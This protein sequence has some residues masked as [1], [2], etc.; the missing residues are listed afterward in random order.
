MR[1]FLFIAFAGILAGFFMT[2][3]N[4]SSSHPGFKKTSTG[5]YYKFYHK[6]GDTTQPKIAEFAMVEMVYGTPDSVLFDSRKLPAS[7][8]PMKIPMIRSIYKG[9]IYEG[10]EMMHVG[11][12]AVFQ[13]NADSV[14]KKL[15]RMRKLPAFVDT[16]KDVYFAIKLVG[17]KTPQQ[18]QAEESARL[19]KLQNTESKERVAYLK[20][21]NITVKPTKDGLY[22]IPEKPGK[23]R[24]PKI[25][26]RVSVHYTGYLLNGKKFDSSRDRGKPF[27]FTLGK[28]QVIPGW[29]EGIAMLRKGGT[30][31]LIVPSSLGYGTRNMGPIPPFSTLVFDVELV[32][33]QHAAKPKK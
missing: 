16:T 18:M 32:N 13:C 7:K 26:D 33:I 17:V 21:N 31:K 5:L 14:F 24:H 12:S 22:F 9:D 6:S 28:H 25:G 3:C 23:G 2:S 30:A 29:D 27:E 19:M 10:I 15:F 8:R 4:Q 20:K 11:D 1:K